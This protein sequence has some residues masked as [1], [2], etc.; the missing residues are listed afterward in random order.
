LEDF[1]LCFEPFGDALAQHTMAAFLTDPGVRTPVFMRFSTVQGAR[2]STAR[3]GM[4][5]GSR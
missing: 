5:A 3:R 4:C 2:G 1:Q